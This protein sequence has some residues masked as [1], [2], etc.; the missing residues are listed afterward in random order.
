MSFASDALRAE[1]ARFRRLKI[2]IS[3]AQAGKAIDDY[4]KELEERARALDDQ[5]ASG[6]S[7]E[8]AD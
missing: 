4:A 5:A 8:D 1:A 2:L 3:D 6:P 7:T